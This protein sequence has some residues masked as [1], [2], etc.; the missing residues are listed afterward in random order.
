MDLADVVQERAG[1]Q[2]VAIDLR[3][4]AAN[5]ITGREQRNHVI[6][7]SADVG[8]VQASWRRAR[9]GRLLQSPDRP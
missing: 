4:V 1:Q 2:Q 5:Q 7:Q 8:M 9:C 3:I 6:E